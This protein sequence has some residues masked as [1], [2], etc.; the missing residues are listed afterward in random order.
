M[1]AG[2]P[3]SASPPAPLQARGSCPA[4]YLGVPS[5]CASPAV[6]ALFPNNSAAAVLTWRLAAVPAPPPPPGLGPDFTGFGDPIQRKWTQLGGAATTGLSS[7][8]RLGACNGPDAECMQFYANGMI[9]YSPV[10]GTAWICELA[11]L[12]VCKH[13]CK[14][15]FEAPAK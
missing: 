7:G 3:S 2:G 9:V 5:A 10:Y 11:P 12:H 8:G 1:R 6:P 15:L 13:V 4:R 14:Q